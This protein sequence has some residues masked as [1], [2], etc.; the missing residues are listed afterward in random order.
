MDIIQFILINNVN[1]KNKH[2]I[3][4]EIKINIENKKKINA[5]FSIF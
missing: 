5:K 1:Q 3:L 2:F 4:W